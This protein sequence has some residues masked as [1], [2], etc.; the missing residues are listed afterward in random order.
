M[1]SEKDIRKKEKKLKKFQDATQTPTNR[2]KFLAEYTGT[3]VEST[4]QPLPMAV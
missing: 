4:P 3:R 1:A 2:I